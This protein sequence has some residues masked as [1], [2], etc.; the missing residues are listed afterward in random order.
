MKR[1]PQY[2]HDWWAMISTF[3]K[4]LWIVA[5]LSAVI[6]LFQ[7]FLF[8]NK[9]LKSKT[10]GENQTVEPEYKCTFFDCLWTFQNITVFVTFFSWTTLSLYNRGWTTFWSIAGG[11]VAGLF[12]FLGFAYVYYYFGDD[13][14]NTGEEEEETG[15]DGE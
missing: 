11:I 3:E 7:V 15:D 4:V 10:T 2:L 12:F 14:I 13:Y 5:A 6:F 1:E 9:Y 8:F